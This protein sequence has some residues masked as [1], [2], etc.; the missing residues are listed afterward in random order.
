MNQILNNYIDKI[1]DRIMYLEQQIAAGDRLDGYEL[2]GHRK[3]LKILKE[4]LK[5]INNKK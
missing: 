2:E 5:D 1:Q 3:E 4:E